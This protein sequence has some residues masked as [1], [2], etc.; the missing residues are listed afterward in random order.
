M[1]CIGV[2]MQDDRAE[3]FVWGFG[4][5]DSAAQATAEPERWLIEH[6]VIHERYD[7]K[8]VYEQLDTF[9]L[10]AYP[11]KSGAELKPTV[12]AVDSGDGDHAPY[13]YEYA[14]N[15]TRQC[16][17][18]TKG[19]PQLGKP[20]INNGK[21]TEFDMKGRPRKTSAIMY[22]VGTDGIKTRLM[23]QLR[24]GHQ[25]G[26]GAIHFPSD[27]TEEFFVQLVSERR[28]HGTVGG[29]PKV[30]WVRRKG[31]RAEALDGA[32]YAD[33]AF[34]HAKKKYNQ[35]TMWQQ[36]ATAIENQGKPA[37][38]KSAVAFNLLDGQKVY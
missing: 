23:A 34:H 3:V 32:V 28:H 18:A 38:K 27:T 14:N 35:K 1:I 4:P 21:R 2:D 17:I 10:G 29:Q 13:V 7:T 24:H 30:T 19:M 25:E 26:A 16:V 9:L 6:A 20:P 37:P 12:M 5:G 36:I 22:Q 15:R 11:L 31:T 8:A 33:A